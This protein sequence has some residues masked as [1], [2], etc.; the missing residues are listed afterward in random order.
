MSMSVRDQVRAFIEKRFPA[1]RL[2]AVGDDDPL[3]GSG[4]L[5]S[6]GVLDVVAYVETTFGIGVTDQDLTPENFESI[7]SMAAFVTARRH[8]QTR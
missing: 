5:D 7:T 4:V 1:A 6:L 2:R 3:L 8:E